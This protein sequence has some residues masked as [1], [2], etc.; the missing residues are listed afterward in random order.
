MQTQLITDAPRVQLRLFPYQR[1]AVDAIHQAFRSGIR[2]PALSAATGSG[3][4]VMFSKVIEESNERALVI[5]HR[6]EIIEQAAQKVG[7]VIDQADVGIVMADRNQFG[8]PVVVASIQTISNPRRL[9]RLGAFGLVVV[10]EAH[11]AA[12]P[13]LRRRP[14]PARRGRGARHQGARCQRDLGPG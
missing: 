3:K 12:S 9:A 8:A 6:K 13:L 10:D 7:Y 1:D 11:H 5:A 2:R 4:T 14:S